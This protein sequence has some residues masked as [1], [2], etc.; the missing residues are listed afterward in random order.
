MKSIDNSLLKYQQAINMAA[1]GW[2]PLGV[3]D[4]APGWMRPTVDLEVERIV[5]DVKRASDRYSIKQPRKVV[6]GISPQ[7]WM[8][9][10]ENYAMPSRHFIG[11]DE[12]TFNERSKPMGLSKTHEYATLGGPTDRRLIVEKVLGRNPEDATAFLAAGDRRNGV[13]VTNADSVP[14]ALNVLG[15]D[16]PGTEMHAAGPTSYNG[17]V[18]NKTIPTTQ[19]KRDAN[20][21]KAIDLLRGADVFDQRTAAN[22]AADEVEAAKKKAI[23]EA[24]AAAARAVVAER[25]IA[26]LFLRKTKSAYS[27]A[28]ADQFW[29]GINAESVAKVQSALSAYE[30]ARRKVEG[31]PN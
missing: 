24:A 25:E 18:A 7:Q 11:I 28:I 13:F 14:L 26:E 5:A 1:K 17:H 21:A 27:E 22:K 31:L 29:V 9:A 16:R 6:A 15:Y 19:W 8:D 30:T 12:A 4:P 20:V 23:E 3:T 2:A 10:V